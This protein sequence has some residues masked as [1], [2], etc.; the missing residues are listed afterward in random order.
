MARLVPPI[1]AAAALAAL[2]QAAG[3]APDRAGA[4]PPPRPALERTAPEH[5][6]RAARQ[7]APARAPR[8]LTLAVLTGATQ[9]EA[10]ARI[11]APDLARAEGAGAL[12]TYRLKDCAL[13]VF[14]RSRDG[15]ALKLSGATSSPRRRDEA[16]PPVDACLAEAAARR[17][18]GAR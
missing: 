12:W 1:L 14:F 2:G 6:G 4:R 13:L 5:A 9:A 8:P 17:T 7:K 10:R 16:P 15:G 18:A 11:G 3:A